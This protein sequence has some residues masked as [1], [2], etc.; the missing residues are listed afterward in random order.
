MKKNKIIGSM[1]MKD[2]FLLLLFTL[3][4][5][6]WAIADFSGIR[7]TEAQNT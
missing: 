3:W 7:Q 2:P 1:F 4:K 5:V 6:R